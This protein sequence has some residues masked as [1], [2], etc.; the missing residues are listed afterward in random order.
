MKSLSR[1]IILF[2]VSLVLLIS[3]PNSVVNAEQPQNPT[4]SVESVVVQKGEDIFVKIN[5]SSNPGICFAL[6]EVEYSQELDLINAWDEGLWGLPVFENNLN[7]NPVRLSWDYS[8]DGDCALNGTLVTLQFALKDDADVGEYWVKINYDE[9]NIFN[10][11]LQ[12]VH[13]DTVDAEIVIKPID[14]T[15]PTDPTE[16]T[17]FPWIIIVIIVAVIVIAVVL[18]LLLK[19]KA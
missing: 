10:S 12:N 7:S 1:C 18:L 17:E 5:V 11:D 6:I 8:E 15:V 4:L 9:E 16:P 13:F 3:T 2:F 14:P 19:N